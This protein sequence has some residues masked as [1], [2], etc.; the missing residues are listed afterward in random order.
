MSLELYLLDFCFSAVPAAV[1]AMLF[2]TPLKYVPYAAL[3][4][5][6]AHITR[7]VCINNV[8]FGIVAS[9]F[10]ASITISLMFIF[11]SPRLRVPR[12]VFTVASIVPIIPGKFAYLTLLSIIQMRNA[13]ETKAG[14]I[15]SFFENGI[16]TST[17]LLAI[18]MGIA[19]PALLFYPNRPVV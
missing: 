16:I 18:G 17:V 12:L 11:L 1:F 8:G 3:G 13:E 2:N 6:V 10:I 15:E 5:A 7:T 4:G 9:S 14:L 19:M